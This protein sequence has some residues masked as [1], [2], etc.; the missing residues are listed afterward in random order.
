MSRRFSLAV[1]VLGTLL[2]HAAASAQT[3]APLEARLFFPT[4]PPNSTFDTNTPIKISLQIRNISGAD[5]I[6]INGFS[7]T[8]FWRLRVG[9]LRIVYVIDE[10]AGQ[11]VV[12][13]VA[14]RAESTYRRV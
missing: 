3:T 12:L 2:L 13:R 9:D 7:A 10:A 4:P 14:R 6:T 8:D 1:L 11:V 5:V